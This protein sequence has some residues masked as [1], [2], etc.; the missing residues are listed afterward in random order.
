LKSESEREDGSTGRAEI[1]IFDKGAYTSPYIN[2][3]LTRSSIVNII[4]CG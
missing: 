2:L 1:I 3:T 4:G